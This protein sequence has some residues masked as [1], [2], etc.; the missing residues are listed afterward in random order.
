M[1]EAPARSFVQGKVTGYSVGEH[2]DRGHNQER[3]PFGNNNL[4]EVFAVNY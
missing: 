2:K 3:V 1:Q 4:Y